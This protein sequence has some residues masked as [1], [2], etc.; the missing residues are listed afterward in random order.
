[1]YTSKIL[2]GA[3]MP[4]NTATI[5][6]RTLSASA[7]FYGSFLVAR[8]LKVSRL[9][10]VVTTLVSAS[11]TAPQLAFYDRP[12]PGSSSGQVQIGVLTI[13][14]GAVVGAVYYKDIKG[15]QLAPGHELAIDHLTQAVDGSSAAGAALA[16]F[17]AEDDPETAVNSSMILSA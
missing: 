10:A 12:I 13:P 11:V 15:Y 6:P 9:M 5:A 8:N 2:A 7:G 1:M 14:N 3:V 4:N 16:L 17:E